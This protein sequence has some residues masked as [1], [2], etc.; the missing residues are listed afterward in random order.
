M[1]SPSEPVTRVQNSPA[2][3]RVRRSVSRQVCAVTKFLRGDRHVIPMF[4]CFGG[5]V[6]KFEAV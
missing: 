5:E 3:C 4:G 2:A 1:T 6:A